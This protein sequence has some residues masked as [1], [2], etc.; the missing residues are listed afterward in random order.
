MVGVGIGPPKVL[1][2]PKPTSSVRIKRTF[3]APCGAWTSFGKSGVDPLTVRPIL[4]LN[5]GSGWGNTSGAR[6]VC[7][8]CPAD[9]PCCAK[10]AVSRSAAKAPPETPHKRNT[11]VRFILSPLLSDDPRCNREGPT[12]SCSDYGWT[13]QHKPCQCR[14]GE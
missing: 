2:A 7:V 5:G 13:H 14:Q 10:V 12:F 11:L 3:G 8:T 4:P 9:P 6:G 1:E